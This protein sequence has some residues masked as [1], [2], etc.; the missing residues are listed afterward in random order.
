MEINTP[1][2]SKLD[3]PHKIEGAPAEAKKSFYELARSRV[4]LV[5]EPE[6]FRF[7]KDVFGKDYWR[8][9]S[10]AYILSRDDRITEDSVKRFVDTLDIKVNKDFFFLEGEDYSDLIPYVVEHEIYESYLWSKKGFYQPKS[11]KA[12]HLSDTHL[13]ARRKEFELAMQDG[14]AER[15]LEFYKKKIYSIEDESDYASHKNEL[16]Y[17]YQKALKRHEKIKK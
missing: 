13:L 11:N 10:A 6:Y 3:K 9:P 14:K 1:E 15:L 12:K 8:Y 2:Y 7:K 17:A 16:D 4:E 5:A